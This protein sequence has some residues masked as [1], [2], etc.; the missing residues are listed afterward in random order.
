MQLTYLSR[1]LA[2][3]RECIQRLRREHRI[4]D[5][6]TALSDLLVMINEGL[7]ADAQFS[8]EEA[9]LALLEMENANQVMY[10]N[11]MVIII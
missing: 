8:K 5:T 2:L 11:E 10:R 1:S 6:S 4:D 3:F 9:E 7:T